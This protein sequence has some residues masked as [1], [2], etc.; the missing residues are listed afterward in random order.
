MRFGGF[1][2]ERNLYANRWA[3]QGY[4]GLRRAASAAGFHVVLKTFYSPIP[5]LEELPP[6]TME[7]RSSLAGLRFDLDEQLDWVE[8]ELSAPMREFRPAGAGYGGPDEYRLGTSSYGELDATVLY[9]ML[10]R[11]QPRRV[12]E[13]GSGAS[14]L[15]TAQAARANERDGAPLRLEVFDPFPS[16]VN[17][18][19][20]NLAS[21]QRMP[22]QQ[23]PLAVFEELADGDVLFVD[24]THTV[25]L[26]SDVNFI[27]LDVLPQLAPGVI[28]HFHD[29]FLPYEYPR[30][31]LE[32]FALFWT[33]QYL[34]QAFLAQN[35]EWDVLCAVAALTRERQERFAA[36]LPPDIAPRAGGAFWMRRTRHAQPTER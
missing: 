20:P 2:R 8:A 22:A 12:V 31:W 5:A 32:D 35:R 26:G 7:R 4:R 19:L 6:G 36:T 17:D 21:L 25:K 30:R 14:T 27:V 34:L 3:V 9:G 33:E 15:V 13:L 23:V 18:D 28:V 1:F 10:R 29:I 11:L 24:T 16:I